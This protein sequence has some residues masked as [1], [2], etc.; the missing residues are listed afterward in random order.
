[1]RRSY[2]YAS[3]TKPET[4]PLNR[5]PTNP[6]SHRQPDI[7][8]L[9]AYL[10]DA[11][12]ITPS[13]VDVALNDQ[14]FMDD[15]MRFGDVLVARGWVKQ[16]TL[17]Y[18][19]EKVVEPEQS[20]ARRVVLEE[21]M[22]VRHLHTAPEIMPQEVPEPKP[23]VAENILA[24]ARSLDGDAVFQVVLPPLEQTTRTDPTLSNQRRSLSSQPEEKD[25]L[26]W[27]G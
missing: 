12:L 18:L 13:Q 6:S 14:E 11:G 1:M 5:I 19:I 26:N 24:E 4:S 8:R 9:G 3:D 25:G 15:G 21:S 22:T 10:I 23:V 2:M 17:D 20:I 16:Q 27:V 7:K